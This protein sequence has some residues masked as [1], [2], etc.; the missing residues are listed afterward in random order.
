MGLSPNQKLLFTSPLQTSIQQR[1]STTAMRLKKQQEPTWV[2]R[3]EHHSEVLVNIWTYLTSMLTDSIPDD[4]I[5]LLNINLQPLDFFSGKTV[6][7]LAASFDPFFMPTNEMILLKQKNKCI[8]H[9][10]QFPP[11][12]G[13]PPKASAKPT[14]QDLDLQKDLVDELQKFCL[15]AQKYPVAKRMSHFE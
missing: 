1:G 4:L 5:R 6:T 7:D 10:V 3:Y 8:E 15:L 13:K 11:H 9:T 12:T 14:S 2:W